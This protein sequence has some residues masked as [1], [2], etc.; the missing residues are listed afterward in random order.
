MYLHFGKQKTG[1]SLKNNEVLQLLIGFW[2]NHYI[3]FLTI[4]LSGKKT[5]QGE[6]NSEKSLMRVWET[7]NH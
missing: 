4:R 5:I 7:Q 6:K 1:A 3:V 2:Y